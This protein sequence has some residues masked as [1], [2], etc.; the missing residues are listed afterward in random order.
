MNENKKGHRP[1]TGNSGGNYKMKQVYLT[2]S[3]LSRL[4]DLVTGLF[5]M[6]QSPS[7]DNNDRELARSWFDKTLRQYVEVTHGI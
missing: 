7:L 5:I 1:G 4:S 6:T 2:A 3:N